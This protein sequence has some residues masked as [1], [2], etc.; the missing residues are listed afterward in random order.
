MERYWQSAL[1]G[2]LGRLP[3]AIERIAGRPEDLERRQN[4]LFNVA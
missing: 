4:R 2:S 1:T 3:P